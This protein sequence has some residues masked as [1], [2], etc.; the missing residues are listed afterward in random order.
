L[1]LLLK[2]FIGK[3]LGGKP[4]YFGTILTRKRN[5]IDCAEIIADPRSFV[6][7]SEDA[8]VAQFVRFV[9]H[10]R[11]YRRAAHQNLKRRCRVLRAKCALLA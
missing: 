8:D 6:S 5:Q 9:R 7:T 4:G 11:S 1:H 3:S 10:R 2:E